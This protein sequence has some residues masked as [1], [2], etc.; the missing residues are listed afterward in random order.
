MRAL[1]IASLV[2]AA[3]HAELRIAYV[4]MG[5]ALEESDAGKA[6]RKQLEAETQKRQRE[7]D[8]QVEKLKQARAA[9]ED[10]RKMLTADAVERR[11]RDLQQG[12]RLLNDNMLKL[13]SEL[14]ARERAVVAP[15]VTRLRGAVARIADREHFVL[16]LDRSSVVYGP[17]SQDITSEVIRLANAAPS[18]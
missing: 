13:Q 2:S 14:E 18:P 17:A 10:A 5:R 12:L 8:A 6:A 1:I 15:V 11:E 9:F 3:A 4:D 16:V 7:L